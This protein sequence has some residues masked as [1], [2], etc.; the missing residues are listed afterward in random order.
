MVGKSSENNIDGDLLLSTNSIIT[1]LG[2]AWTER[3]G[4]GA[5]AIMI[6]GMG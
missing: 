4:Q 5:R 3:G 6:E 2:L 1:D